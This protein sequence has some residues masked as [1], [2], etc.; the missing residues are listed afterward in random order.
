[1]AAKKKAKGKTTKRRKA[2][3]RQARKTVPT[4]TV[5]GTVEALKDLAVKVSEIP[6]LVIKRAGF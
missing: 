1:M 3:K 5:R 2:T 6:G 4:V